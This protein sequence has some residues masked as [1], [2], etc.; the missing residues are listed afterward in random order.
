MKTDLI[1]N[2]QILADQYQSLAN[3]KKDHLRI[4]SVARLISFVGVL[5]AW[6]YLSPI[7]ETLAAVISLT[8][9]VT[10]FLLIKKFIQA[11]KQLLYFQQMSKINRNEIAALNRDLS[12]FDPGTEFTVG[13]A[14]T[15]LTALPLVQMTSLSAFTS[16]LQLM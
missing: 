4:I 14:L 9:L 6:F 10:F 15:I 13:A 7:N 2:Y 3:K 1:Q 16:A 8:L 11:E 5:P 12:A